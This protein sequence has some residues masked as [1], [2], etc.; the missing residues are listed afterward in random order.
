MIPNWAYHIDDERDYEYWEVHKEE[1]L[2]ATLPSQCILDNVEY[3]NQALQELTLMW[4]VYY[5]SWHWSN[6][7]NFQEWSDIRILNKDLCEIAI[8]KKYL[9]IKKWSLVENWPKLLKE[10]WYINWRTLIQTIDEAKHSIINKK[11]IVVWSKMINWSLWYNDPFVLW[12]NS[13]S[14][15]CVL[16]IWYNDNYEWWCFIIKQSYWRD[17]Y[18]EWK[19]YLKYEDFNLLF[20]WK[21]SIEDTPDPILIYKKNIMNDINIPKAV[22]AFENWFWNWKEPTK[23]ASREEV[24]TMMQRVYEKLKEDNK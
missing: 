12:W 5:S 24:A 11:P 6:E 4:C 8:E 9:D 1:L 14:W 2:W 19:Q 7:L 16:I 23:P 15:H 18:S 17:R 21:Y 22:E 10:L 13:W 20:N 3:Q